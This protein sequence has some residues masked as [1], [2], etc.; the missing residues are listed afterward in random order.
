[1]TMLIM[2]RLTIAITIDWHK[3]LLAYHKALSISANFPDK[4]EAVQPVQS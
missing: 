1:M 4:I 3:L 2:V